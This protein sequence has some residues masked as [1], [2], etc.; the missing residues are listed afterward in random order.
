ME[1]KGLTINIEEYVLDRGESLSEEIDFNGWKGFDDSD[2]VLN[3]IKSLSDRDKLV[4]EFAFYGGYFH[5][6][7]FICDKLFKKYLDDFLIGDQ[8]LIDRFDIIK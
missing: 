4:F 3:F 6:A 7:S 1:N 2:K 5:G 8:S